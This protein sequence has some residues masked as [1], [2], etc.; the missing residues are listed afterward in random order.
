MTLTHPARLAVAAVLAFGLGLL[1]TVLLRGAPS[2]PAPSGSSAIFDGAARPAPGTDGEIARLQ[3]ALRAT[4]G[5][6]DRETALADAY[7]QKVRETGDV[8]FY[9]KADGLLRQAAARKPNDPGVL[10]SQATL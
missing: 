3:A 7:L 4:P 9:A 6:A 8:T 10:V 2:V 1:L 5:N